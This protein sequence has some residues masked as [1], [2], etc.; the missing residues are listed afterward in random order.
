MTDY[1]LTNHWCTLPCYEHLSNKH[2]RKNGPKR[3]LRSQ[4]GQK[5][6]QVLPISHVLN[7]GRTPISI[8]SRNTTN[9]STIIHPYHFQDH[10]NNEY[11]SLLFPR[12]P[13]ITYND[14]YKFNPPPS[15]TTNQSLSPV[16][17][18][19]TTKKKSH[20]ILPT[21]HALNNTIYYDT[22]RYTMYSDHNNSNP[23]PSS[24]IKQSVLP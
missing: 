11:P 21:R 20:E 8:W 13:N 7:N 16:I 18:P 1:A 2:T 17:R 23:P 15:S 22:Y 24:R 6:T 5:K 12:S 19:A 10:R 3:A 4:K 9:C 14:H